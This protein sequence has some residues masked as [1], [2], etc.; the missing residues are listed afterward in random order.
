MIWRQCLGGMKWQARF[1]DVALNQN[2]RQVCEFSNFFPWIH[3]PVF[4]N[5]MQMYENS[6]VSGSDNRRLFQTV[7]DEYW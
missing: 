5:S 1:D 6:S 4:L 7:S 2:D 3:A